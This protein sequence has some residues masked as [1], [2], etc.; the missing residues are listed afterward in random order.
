MRTN[1]LRGRWGGGCWEKASQ[2]RGVRKK[3]VHLRNCKRLV[4]PS[5]VME[6]VVSVR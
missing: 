6:R 4:W 2:V 3:R 1:R 5:A